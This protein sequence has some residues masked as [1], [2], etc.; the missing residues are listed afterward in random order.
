MIDQK[1]NKT[2]EDLEQSLKDIDSARKQVDS[3]VKSSGSL[4][5]VMTNFVNQ[6]STVTTKVQQLVDAVGN[7][8]DQKVKSFEKDRE[9]VINSSKA[10]IE[11]LNQTTRQFKESLESISTKL[12]FSIFLNIISL[13]AIGYLLYMLMH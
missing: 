6:L 7:D 8:Y 2:L 9:S 5:T 3:V 11:K 4:N 1:I 10:A 13:A 12:E